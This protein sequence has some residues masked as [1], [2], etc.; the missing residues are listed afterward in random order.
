MAFFGFVL[1]FFAPSKL[2]FVVGRDILVLKIL[3]CKISFSY[4][5]FFG[6]SGC[7]GFRLVMIIILDLFISF[8]ICLGHLFL[9]SIMS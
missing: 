7:F 3:C 8:M 6:G 9:I 2:G 4:Y 1:F 5:S